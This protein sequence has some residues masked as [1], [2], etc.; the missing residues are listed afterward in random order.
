MHVRLTFQP[1]LFF[2][3]F[4]LSFFFH[5]LFF[6]RIEKRE[7]TLCPEFHCGE[8]TAPWLNVYNLL[9][10]AAMSCAGMMLLGLFALA[11]RRL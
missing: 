5:F 1:Q 6:R 7:N 2:L 4:F 3:S 8:A 10:G 9:F 11:A